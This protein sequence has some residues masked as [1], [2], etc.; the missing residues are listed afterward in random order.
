M[1]TA[2]SQDNNLRADLHC[3][4]WFEVPQGMAFKV[5]VKM[6]NATNDEVLELARM[7]W[8]FNVSQGMRAISTR[9]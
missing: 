2:I 9:P 6:K 8:D 5:T 4:M 3:E 1:F 7:N